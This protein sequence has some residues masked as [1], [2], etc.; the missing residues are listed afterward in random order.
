[1]AK[2]ASDRLQ[3]ATGAAQQSGQTNYPICEAPVAVSAVVTVSVVVTA[4]AA[5][6]L[7]Q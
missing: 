5:V 7:R 4:A 2:Y 6:G 1:L 3:S